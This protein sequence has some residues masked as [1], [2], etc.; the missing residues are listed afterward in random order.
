MFH[1]HLTVDSH[2]N[3]FYL[4]APMINAAMNILSKYQ[5]RHVFSG[6]SGLYLE[7]E[8]LGDV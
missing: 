3:C 4:L 1:I 7:V 5:N 8:L 2:S 6:L